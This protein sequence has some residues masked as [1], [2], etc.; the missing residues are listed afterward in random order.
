MK[1]KTKGTIMQTIKKSLI[2]AIFVGIIGTGVQA[3]ELNDLEKQCR[4]GDGSAC[5]TAGALYVGIGNSGVTPD[6]DKAVA[7]WK[8]GC[9]LDNGSACTTYAMVLTDENARITILK[10]ACDLGNENGCLSYEHLIRMQGLKHDCMVKQDLQSCRKFAG[11]I[12]MAGSFDRGKDLIEDICK[13]GDTLSCSDFRIIDERN[14][15]VKLSF[16][17]ELKK[18]CSEKK[19]YACEKVGSFLIDINQYVM[20]PLQTKSEKAEALPEV[21]MNLAFGE[22]YLKKACSLGRKESCRILR[23]LQKR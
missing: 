16:V 1:M 21:M 7:L 22:S 19:K 6:R 2:S 8:R 13:L 5:A 20:A 23:G 11:E 15:F 3:G 17:E 9:E 12:F 14:E 10:K 4:L 18:E